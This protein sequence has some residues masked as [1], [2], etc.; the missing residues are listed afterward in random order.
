MYTASGPLI[1]LKKEVSWL[2]EKW[3]T[4]LPCCRWSPCQVHGPQP[5]WNLEWQ[6]SDL[7]CTPGVCPSWV[8][9]ELIVCIF[10]SFPTCPCL[11]FSASPCEA[12]S[13]FPGPVEAPGT[14][15][16]PTLLTSP[17]LFLWPGHFR[18]CQLFCPS[19]GFVCPAPQL[20][21]ISSL[22]EL[23]R[24]VSFP[25]LHLEHLPWGLLLFHSRMLK[26]SH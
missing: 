18:G 17:S 8:P 26:I 23:A 14:P 11:D 20:I 7:G 15:S 25:L 12:I 22:Q 4:K 13:Y 6:V 16:T 2:L 9:Y 10:T 3:L 21:S 24:L 19:A 1:P 5:Q